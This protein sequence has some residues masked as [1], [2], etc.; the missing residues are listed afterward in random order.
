[1]IRGIHHVQLIIPPGGEGKARPF[2]FQTLGLPEIEKPA[3]LEGVVD[4]GFRRVIARS[5]S[6]SRMAPSRVSVPSS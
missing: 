3:S 2:Y 4:C 1:M 6:V 5:I